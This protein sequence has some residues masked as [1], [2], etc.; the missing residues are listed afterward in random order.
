MTGAELCKQGAVSHS[1][2]TD[3]WCNRLAKR[4][5]SEQRCQGN[6]RDRATNKLPASLSLSLSLSLPLSLLR[7]D[8]FLFLLPGPEESLRAWAGRGPSSNAGPSQGAEMGGGERRGGSFDTRR[9][10]VSDREEHSEGSRPKKRESKAGAVAGG[11]GGV[12]QAGRQCQ[13][14][15]EEQLQKKSEECNEKSM[16]RALMCF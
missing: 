10:R 16:I 6:E 15:V 12:I 9:G 7:L 4:R 1:Q 5:V 8:S 3:A 2:T 11:G 14:T 13:R